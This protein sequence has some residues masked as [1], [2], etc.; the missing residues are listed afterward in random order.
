MVSEKLKDLINRISFDDGILVVREEP[1]NVEFALVTGTDHEVIRSLMT[2]DLGFVVISADD[3][4]M[5]VNS[6]LNRI[7]E[8]GG[9][10]LE[11]ERQSPEEVLGSLLRDI[12]EIEKPSKNGGGFDFRAV[13]D[14]WNRRNRK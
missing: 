2:Q 11:L 12:G 7:L 9:I 10:S 1:E 3:A 14:R 6:K 13:N 5:D 8:I 4:M